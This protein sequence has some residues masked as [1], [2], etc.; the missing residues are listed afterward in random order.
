MVRYWD[1]SRKQDT[2]V[3][4]QETIKDPKTPSLPCLKL[5]RGLIADQ[6]DRPTVSGASQGSGYSVG[7]AGGSALRSRLPDS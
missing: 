1:L 4:L 7:A 5:L 6:N 3:R 2:M